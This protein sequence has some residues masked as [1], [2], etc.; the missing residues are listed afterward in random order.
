VTRPPTLRSGGVC[1]LE[2]VP[3]REEVME[4]VPVE[5]REG[6]TEGVAV[7]EGEPPSVIVAEGVDVEEGE[8]SAI[9]CTNRGAAYTVPG[10]VAGS[11]ADTAKVPGL[12]VR[13]LV[14]GRSP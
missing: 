4:R 3:V 13:T 7:P 1:V 2:G 11:H 6:V 12:P 8:G 9:P 14:T 5:V 10:L